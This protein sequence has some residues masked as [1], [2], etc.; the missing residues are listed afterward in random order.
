[1][2]VKVLNGCSVNNRYW[3]F[4]SA[5]TNVGMNLTVTDVKAGVTKT[6]SN[7]DLT[8]AKPIQDT[9]AFNTCP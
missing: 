1:M 6:Y 3:V 8:A 4:A 2:L 9:D 7:P 5:R